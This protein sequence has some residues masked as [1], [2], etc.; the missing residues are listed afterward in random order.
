MGVPLS[1]VGVIELWVR[2]RREVGLKQEMK[3]EN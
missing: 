2:E 1:K 3:T